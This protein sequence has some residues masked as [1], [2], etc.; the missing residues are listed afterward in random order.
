VRLLVT[1]EILARSAPASPAAAAVAAA[2][3]VVVETAQRCGN[4]A[5]PKRE[6]DPALRAR[7]HLSGHLP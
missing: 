1:A 4:L 5:S 2:A 3:D 6:T 7:S